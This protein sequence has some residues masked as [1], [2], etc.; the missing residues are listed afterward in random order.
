[1]LQLLRVMCAKAVMGEKQMEA[2]SATMVAA[3][4][5]KELLQIADLQVRSLL[6]AVHP[7]VTSAVDFHQGNQKGTPQV[8]GKLALPVQARRAQTVANP[9]M[10]QLQKQ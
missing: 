4:R 9:A 7:V 3:P 2:V 6:K 8:A 1:M 10:G 5:E